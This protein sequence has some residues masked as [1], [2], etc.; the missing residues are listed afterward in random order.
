VRLSSKAA[1]PFYVWAS[2]P[3]SVQA[4]AG[5]VLP[6]SVGYAYLFVFFTSTV[7]YAPR[8]LGAGA[9]SDPLAEPHGR[10]GRLDRVRSAQTAIILVV[11]SLT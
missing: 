1:C 9:V 4:S 6:G 2:T 3:L 11:M 5:S 8:C 7:V 10:E